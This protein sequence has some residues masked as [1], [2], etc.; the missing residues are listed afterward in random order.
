MIRRAIKNVDSEALR[1][2][3]DKR[4]PESN[5]LE[6]K[7]KVPGK[8]DSESDGVVKT[9][10]AFANTAGGR[11]ILGMETE[12]GLPVGLR[13]IATTEIDEKKQWLEN[14]LRDSVEPRVPPLD[15][16]AVEIGNDEHVLVVDVG[17]SWV[18]PHRWTKDK[19][20]YRR[21]SAGNEPL[22]VG[23]GTNGLR[24]LRG[25]HRSDPRVS[26]GASLENTERADTC[27]TPTR[28]A[29]DAAPCSKGRVL[30]SQ[31]DRHRRAGIT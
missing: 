29:H 4:V 15:I 19:H 30:H 9:V 6:Y 25:I 1:A 27:R 8:A 10:C 14:K 3:I 22:D 2:L 20:F 7:G 5:T 12:D 11:L 17:E 28:C 16:H 26:N 18:A 21:T 24:N 31:C 23:R 13:G